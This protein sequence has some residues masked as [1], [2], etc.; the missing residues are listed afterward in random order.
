MEDE[1]SKESLKSVYKPYADFMNLETS[2]KDC[3]EYLSV[4]SE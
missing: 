4:F 1:E 2:L 3:P